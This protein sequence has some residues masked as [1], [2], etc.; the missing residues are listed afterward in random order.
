MNTDYISIKRSKLWKGTVIALIIVTIFFVF[1]DDFGQSTTGNNVLNKDPYASLSFKE[2]CAKT[3]GMWMKM[4]PTQNYVP[5]GQL[6]CEGC[7]Q[8]RGDHIC[9]KER[10]IKTL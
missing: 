2:I 7:M 1:K 10:Y 6:A 3:G 9:E 8:S 5:T 4:Q